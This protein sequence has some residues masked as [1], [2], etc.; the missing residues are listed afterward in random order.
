MPLAPKQLKGKN[1]K[2]NPKNNRQNQMVIGGRGGTHAG[3]VSD[4]PAAVDTTATN[5]VDYDDG[6]IMK[7]FA[8]A[9]EPA[10]NDTAYWSLFKVLDE[11]N[12]GV[13][14]SNSGNEIKESGGKAV[15]VKGPKQNANAQKGEEASYVISYDKDS[16]NAFMEEINYAYPDSLKATTKHLDGK[17]MKDKFVNDDS[18]ES[19]EAVEQWAAK[20]GSG[21]K[22]SSVNENNRTVSDGVVTSNEGR[23][24]VTG[25]NN[26]V[27]ADP[28]FDYDQNGEALKSWDE[29]LQ[30]VVLNSKK[31]KEEKQ[32]ANKKAYGGPLRIPRD[33]RGKPM[34]KIDKLSDDRFDYFI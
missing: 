4:A 24:R 29:Y 32:K 10:K 12:I 13:A 3:F 15:I 31:K 9:N 1:N 26:I 8:G 20:Y 27:S 18:Q 7:I 21:V 17:V 5:A 19:K 6:A 34:V 22:G 25:G 2:Q 14:T 33:E 28:R 16:G 30:T 23:Y 11:G